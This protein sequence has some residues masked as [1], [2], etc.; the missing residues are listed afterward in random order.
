MKFRKFRPDM[1][2]VTNFNC[3][4]LHLISLNFINIYIN[5]TLKHTMSALLMMGSKNKIRIGKGERGWRVRVAWSL[6]VDEAAIGC[7]VAVDIIKRDTRILKRR[8]SMGSATR[9]TGEGSR[10]E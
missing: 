2:K 9:E 8:D 10:G 4:S 7:G 5:K 6:L 3:F 1:G